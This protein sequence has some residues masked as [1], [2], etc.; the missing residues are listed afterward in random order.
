MGLEVKTSYER[1]HERK[2]YLSGPE[3]EHVEACRRH[4]E[5]GAEVRSLSGQR[6]LL[7]IIDRLAPVIHKPL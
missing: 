5:V 7:A 6:A 3:R 4:L 1:V 2:D